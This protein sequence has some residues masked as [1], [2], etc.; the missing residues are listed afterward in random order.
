V[1]VAAG[2]DVSPAPEKGV[3]QRDDTAQAVER[4]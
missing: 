4:P 3:C 1:N 2:Q